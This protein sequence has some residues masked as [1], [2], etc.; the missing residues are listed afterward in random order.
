M[1]LYQLKTSTDQIVILFSVFTRTNPFHVHVFQHQGDPVGVGTDLQQLA[2]YLEDTL[3][4]VAGLEQEEHWD[5]EQAELR[6]QY[7]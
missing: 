6:S 4:T 3:V 2:Y 7:L 5:L 1:F